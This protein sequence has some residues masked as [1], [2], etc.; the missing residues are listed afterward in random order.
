[1]NGDVT[2]STVATRLEAKATVRHTD[3]VGVGVA[4]A[5]E[6]QEARFAACEEEPGY[7]A[8]RR[9]ADRTAFH[10]DGRVLEKERTMFIDVAGRTCLPLRRIER[11]AILGAVRI[12]AIGAFHRAFGNPMVEGLSELRPYLRVA[13][14]TQLRLGVLEKTFPD[15]AS[16]GI[17]CRNVEELRLS[18]WRSRR[19]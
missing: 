7:A 4:V 6:T 3:L 5:L 19:A 11:R 14:V 13:P 15:P 8:V 18:K 9:V 12:V 10:T 1:V 16:V 17:Q 2:A